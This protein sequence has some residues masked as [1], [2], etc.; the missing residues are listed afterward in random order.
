MLT[1][2]DEE[3]QKIY[4]MALKVGIL[5]QPIPMKDLVDR[6][7]IPPDIKPLNIDVR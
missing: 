7:F 6:E 4:D 1:P 2:T 5:Q 3:L